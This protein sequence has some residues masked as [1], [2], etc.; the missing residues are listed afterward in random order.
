L[1][2]PHQRKR[3][4]G[5]PGSQGRSESGGSPIGSLRLPPRERIRMI[6][7]DPIGPSVLVGEKVGR[8][9]LVEI[10]RRRSP[11]VE[12]QRGLLA[13]RG[14]ASRAGYVAGAGRG[15]GPQVAP[16]PDTLRIKSRMLSCQAGYFGVARCRSVHANRY[17]G[18]GNAVAC[19]PVPMPPSQQRANTGA[20]RQWTAPVRP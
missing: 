1:G 3:S 13:S 4:G 10:A 18:S 8:L 2:S 17:F 19:Q 12:H 14:G 6:G 7:W 9:A 20:E 5:V 15:S 16:A 11:Q